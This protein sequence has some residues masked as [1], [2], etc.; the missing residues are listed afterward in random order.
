MGSE[1]RAGPGFSKL[2]TRFLLISQESVVLLAVGI[3]RFLISS[4]FLILHSTFPFDSFQGKQII[5]RSRAYIQD[6]SYHVT[7]SVIHNL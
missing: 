7:V 6:K 5:V 3:F 2:K 4:I 1:I